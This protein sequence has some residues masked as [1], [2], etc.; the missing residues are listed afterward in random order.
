VAEFGVRRGPAE[1]NDPDVVIRRTDAGW[2]VE[3]PR[4]R[5]HSETLDDLYSAMT[6]ADLLADELRPGQRPRR[7]SSAASEVEHLRQAIRQLEHALAA[8]VVIERAIGVLAER[9]S[10]SPQAAF[11]Q[12]RR[13]ARGRGQRVHELAGQVVASCT[14]SDVALPDDLTFPEP[15]TEQ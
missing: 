8:R 13:V 11:S 2:R 6:L 14:D 15:V 5:R 7:A 12:L 1:L 10:T 4:P 3:A 9:W